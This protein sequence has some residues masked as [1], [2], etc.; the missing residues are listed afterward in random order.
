MLNNSWVNIW[1]DGANY[2]P[3][4]NDIKL[5]INLESKEVFFSSPE[6]PKESSTEIIK[7]L[8][9]PEESRLV[10]WLELQWLLLVWFTDESWRVPKYVTEALKI[11]DWSIILQPRYVKDWLQNGKNLVFVKL[12]WIEA[13]LATKGIIKRVEEILN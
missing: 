7:K 9:T 13:V 12:S 3:S 5:E 8:L 4:M 11:Q 1:N 10:K 2:L 6:L